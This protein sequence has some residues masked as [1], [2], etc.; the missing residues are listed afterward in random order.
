MF[1]ACDAGFGLTTRGGDLGGSRFRRLG[2]V[3]QVAT[4]YLWCLRDYM[5]TLLDSRSS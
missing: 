1:R 4:W 3:V 2:F 5:R